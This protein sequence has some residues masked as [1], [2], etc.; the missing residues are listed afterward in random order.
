VNLYTDSGHA[1]VHEKVGSSHSLGVS[2]D[3]AGQGWALH[4]SVSLEKQSSASGTD[5]F[6]G[7]TR[8]WNEVNAREYDDYCWDSGHTDPHYNFQMR[9]VSF[10]MFLTRRDAA[11]FA[12]GEPVPSGGGGCGIQ[13]YNTASTRPHPESTPC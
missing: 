9:P 8:L 13:P 5:S 7:N 1:T 2:A 4:G 3:Y 10:H 11:P 6:T 12:G